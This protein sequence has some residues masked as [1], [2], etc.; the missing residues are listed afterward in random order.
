M[1]IRIMADTHADGP[2]IHSWYPD[3]GFGSITFTHGGHGNNLFFYDTADIDAVIAE[4]VALKQEMDPPVIGDSA[5]VHPRLRNAAPHHRCP[6]ADRAIAGKCNELRRL[7]R[8]PAGRR[9]R[10][11]RGRNRG[12]R[13]VISG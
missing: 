8:R 3:S 9:R 2:V 6:Q 5:P 11:R 13:R 4:L 10:E 1:R 12:H 7:A